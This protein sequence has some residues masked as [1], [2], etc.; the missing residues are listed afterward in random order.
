MFHNETIDKITYSFEG[1]KS[2][3]LT[4]TRTDQE[5]I[6]FHIDSNFP[7][8]SNIV[9]KFEKHQGLFHLSIVSKANLEISNRKWPIIHA[10]WII[11]EAK[12]Q[13]PASFLSPPKES[14]SRIFSTPL[15][16]SLSPPPR[17]TPTRYPALPHNATLHDCPLTSACRPID[18]LPLS[19]TA[20]LA[21]TRR[22]IRINS[23]FGEEEGLID[24]IP[25]KIPWFPR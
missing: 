19:L 13:H 17:A 15:P 25:S 4:N 24:T 16:L 10:P 21:E 14:G 11:M 20:L 7:L 12:V 6:Y 8:G 1:F 2:D 9:D 5:I 23:R 3:G 18:L 22:I